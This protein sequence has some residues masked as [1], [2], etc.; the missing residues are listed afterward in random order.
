MLCGSRS[1]RTHLD[2]VAVSR[3]DPAAL[4]APLKNLCRYVFLGKV[5]RQ[6]CGRSR[7]M[8]WCVYLYQDKDG[9]TGG[10]EAAG[11][12]AEQV[13]VGY[14]PR[15]KGGNDSDNNSDSNND[16]RLGALQKHKT[17][18]AQKEAVS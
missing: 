15:L 13:L 6:I 11:S 3:L 1:R 18:T 17:K 14:E 2:L 8:V 7:A 10:R 9:R 5:A 12:K 16:N 4:T